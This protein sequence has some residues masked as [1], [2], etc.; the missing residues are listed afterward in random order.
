MMVLNVLIALSLAGIGAVFWLLKSESPEDQV[1]AP[2]KAVKNPLK[3]H[4]KSQLKKP[5]KQAYYLNCP[6]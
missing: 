3:N 6:L 1:T 4:L 5:Q 2:P